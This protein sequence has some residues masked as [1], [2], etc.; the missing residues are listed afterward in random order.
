MSDASPLDVDV[1]AVHSGRHEI[2]IALYILRAYTREINVCTTYSTCVCM[3]VRVEDPWNRYC[4]S[5]VGGTGCV[6]IHQRLRRDPAFPPLKEY[7]Y[8]CRL[9]SI[10]EI[11][12]SISVKYD[13]T[14]NP[15]SQFVNDNFLDRSDISVFLKGNSKIIIL[16][17]QYFSI[18]I[19]IY[20]FFYFI[21]FNAKILTKRIII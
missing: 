16:S 4:L 13:I 14:R 11:S 15:R 12:I 1:V 10:Q 6:I 2:G 9:S 5:V 17:S 19:D 18:K 8:S 7:Y 21:N 3:C 20:I